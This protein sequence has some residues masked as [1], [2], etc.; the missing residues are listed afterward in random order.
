MSCW[1]WGKGEGC[2]YA[3]AQTSSKAPAETEV[4]SEDVTDS[5]QSSSEKSEKAKEPWVPNIRRSGW[6]P[7]MEGPGRLTCGDASKLYKRL[8]DDTEQLSFAHE[9]DLQASCPLL[10]PHGDFLRV[11]IF[12]KKDELTLLPS[13]SCL[14]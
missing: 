10:R 4:A 7:W 6:C 2:G 13:P 14:L 5:D 9:H 11:I 3:Q 1:G 12:K 8:Y